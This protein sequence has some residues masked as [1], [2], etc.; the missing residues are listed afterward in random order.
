MKT[1]RI[2]WKTALAIGI[3]VYSAN[4]FSQA[5]D[6]MVVDSVANEQSR[7]KFGFGFGLNFVGGTNISIAPNLIYGVSE[8]V[9]LGGGIQGSYASIKDL[10]NTTTFGFNIIGQYSPVRKLTTLLEFTELRVSTKTET[11][12]GTDT[13]KY[14][15]S[16][17]FVGAGFNITDNIAI[18]AKYNLLYD[19]DE[20]VY[21]SP[22]IPFVNITF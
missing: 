20:S 5:T 3:F 12:T 2:F 15:D 19:E 21:T 22:I 17:L 6:V 10:Q 13:E 16:A 14:W 18:G 1:L 9:S 8:K 7:L 11:P 4:V